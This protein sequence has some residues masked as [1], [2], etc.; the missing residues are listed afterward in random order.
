MCDSPCARSV[1]TFKRWLIRFSF[2]TRETKKIIKGDAR[3]I[4]VNEDEARRCFD[5]EWGFVRPTVD[6]IEIAQEEG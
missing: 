4:A 3:Y 1:L 6:A 2:V 5:E